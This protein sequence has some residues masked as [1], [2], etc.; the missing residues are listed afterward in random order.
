MAK[1]T[2]TLDDETVRTIRRIAERT[3]KPQSLVVREA[4]SRYA[5]SE[6]KL[7]DDERQ[8]R[9]AVLREL[10]P[11]PATRPPAQVDAELG[12]LRRTRRA[13]WRRVSD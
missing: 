5:Q 11:Q 13:G 7:P 9:L 3:R 2:F 6:Q 4:V 10:M 8:R 12:A 1:V